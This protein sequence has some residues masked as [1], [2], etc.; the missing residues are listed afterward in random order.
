MTSTRFSAETSIGARRGAGDA[1]IS[2]ADLQSRRV[3]LDWFE[4]VAIVQA[5]C[6]VLL[7]SRVDPDN[8]SLGPKNV[9]IDSAGSVRIAQ[10]AGEKGEPAMR[11]IGELLRTSLAESPFPV[12][13]RLVITQACSTVPVYAS[14]A[15]LSSALEYFERP[16]R[17]GLIRAVYERAQGYQPVSGNVTQDTPEPEAEEPVHPDKRQHRRIQRTATATSA[18]A[19]TLI[20]LWLVVSQFPILQQDNGPLE[21]IVSSVGAL[22]DRVNPFSASSSPVAQTSAPESPT[23]DASPRRNSARAGGRATR[24]SSQAAV[25]EAHTDTPPAADVSADD[26]L[27]TTDTQTEAF[28]A[29]AVVEASAEAMIYSVNDPYVT[30]PVASYPRVPA[31]PPIP[32]RAAALSTLE[33][34][35][36]ETG[37]VE[38]VK[39]QGRPRNLGEALLVTMNLSAAKTWRFLPAVKDGRPV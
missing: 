5:S 9:S 4:A 37:Q 35:V 19:A 28:A 15:A 6:R 22:V 17:P 29:G 34:L 24:S 8:T 39:V 30:P 3:P 31:E 18:A 7:E 2:L 10:T 27:P 23:I 20:V 21:E 33:L 14:I 32:V 11:Q 12:Q 36:G 38:S 25:P 13:L 1:G 16:D 26:A